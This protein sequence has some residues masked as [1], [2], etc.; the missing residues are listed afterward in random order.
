MKYIYV[1]VALVVAVLFI[2]PTIS[3]Q[4]IGSSQSENS[5]A[6][7]QSVSPMTNELQNVS[8]PPTVL[9]SYLY[10]YGAHNQS[11]NITSTDWTDIFATV[12]DDRGIINYNFSSN[13]T[14]YLIVFDVSYKG[15]NPYGIE[16]VDAL[17][18]IGN[19]SKANEMKA[20]WETAN[21]TSLVKGYTNWQALK[22]GAFPGFSWSTPKI[23]PSNVTNEYVG[24]M[25]ALI[26][27]VFV[28]YFVFNRRK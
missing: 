18:Q 21:K 22:A 3:A 14:Q 9:P 2:V 24:I 1:L 7:V 16:Y 6:Q 13:S 19:L 11:C 27:S 15:L 12:F 26:I 23:L 25:V 4:G 8:Q 28:L 20:F 10:Y 17:S 5:K